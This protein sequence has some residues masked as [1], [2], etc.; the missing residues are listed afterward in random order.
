MPQLLEVS[1]ASKKEA[2]FRI[3]LPKKAAESLSANTGDIIGFYEED[4]RVFLKKMQ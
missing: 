2:S 4:G 1:H 3:S